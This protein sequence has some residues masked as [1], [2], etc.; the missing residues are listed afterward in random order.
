MNVLFIFLDGVG[1]GEDVPERNPFIPANTPT[2]D[3]LLS[4]LKLLA[5]NAPF[6]HVIAHY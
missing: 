4:G 1:L 6:F 3:H 5:K 2:F